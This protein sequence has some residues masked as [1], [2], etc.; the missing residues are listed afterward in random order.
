MS[1]PTRKL[2]EVVFQFLFCHDFFES[3]E[4]EV[5]KTLMH[6]HKIT[7]KYAREAYMRMGLVKEHLTEIDE[8]IALASNDYAFD[9]ICR[10]ERNILRLSVYELFYDESIP[11]KV[12][13]SEAIRL[14]RKFSTNESASFINAVLD[15]LYQGSLE[16]KAAL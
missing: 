15:F 5:L 11:P 16:Q 6:L 13:I 12:A 10:A 8:K 3:D 9:R 4:K 2:R 7:K 1:L 14:T